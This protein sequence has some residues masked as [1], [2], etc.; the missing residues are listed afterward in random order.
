MAAWRGSRSAALAA[1]LGLVVAAAPL[2]VTSGRAAATPPAD[3]PPLVGLPV[4]DALQ[5][6]AELK[7]TTRLD[8]DPLAD[9]VDRSLVLVLDVVDTSIHIDPGPTNA[10][11]LVLGSR[12]PDLTS[13]TAAEALRLAR[14]RGLVVR[15]SPAD[16]PD[17]AIVTEQLPTPGTLVPIDDVVTARV[18]PVVTVPDVRGKSVAEAETALQA[19]GLRLTV[20]RVGPGPDF[21]PVA[22]QRPAAGTLVVAGS[23]VT[24]AVNTR[25][26]RRT[27]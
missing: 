8:P 16:A 3:L 17:T 12:V 25:H 22:T 15:R 13:L 24:A 23:V 14:L 10:V 26:R 2:V 11:R 1:L 4:D 9:G 21:G 5:R 18:I 27:E 20:Q 6:L 19:A 7:V